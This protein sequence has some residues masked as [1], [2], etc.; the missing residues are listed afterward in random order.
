MD[1]RTRAISLT[2]PRK[3]TE[4]SGIVSKN[5]VFSHMGTEYTIPVPHLSQNQVSI[6]LLIAFREEIL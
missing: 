4:L 6:S 5:S 1:W 2:P 3:I